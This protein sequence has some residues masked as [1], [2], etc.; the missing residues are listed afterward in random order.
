MLKVTQ[1]PTCKRNRGGRGGANYPRASPGAD[2]M[3]LRCPVQDAVTHLITCLTF[4]VEHLFF[5]LW[6]LF[7]SP[8]FQNMIQSILVFLPTIPTFY[9][10]HLARIIPENVVAHM[11]RQLTHSN[12]KILA[13]NFNQVWHKGKATSQFEMLHFQNVLFQLQTSGPDIIIC[14]GFFFP[15][16]LLR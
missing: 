9:S 1:I 5:P 2:E 16:P 11:Q 14:F 3:L 4:V 10:Y 15:F 13:S 8:H 12:K 6:V 7:F